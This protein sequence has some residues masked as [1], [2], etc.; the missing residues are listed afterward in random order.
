MPEL[1]TDLEME[2][3]RL[4]A[5]QLFEDTL[6]I[7]SPTTAGGFNPDNWSITPGTNTLIYQGPGSAYPMSARRDRFDVQAE[8]LIFLRQYRII[9]PWTEDE[10]RLRDIVTVTDS[11]D[12]Q[13]IG[14]PL[15]VRDVFVSTNVGYR[16][17]TA[18]DPNE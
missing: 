9:I 17:I 16:R 1:I 6:T 3:I 8:G 15:E 10:I 14:R 4:D 7:H 5:D 13:I 12:P 11:R 18:H 2:G